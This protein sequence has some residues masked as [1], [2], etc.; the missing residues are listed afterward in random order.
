MIYVYAII[1]APDADL[2][3]APGLADRPV[4]FCR[5]GPIAAAFS[6]HAAGISPTSE[7][8][9]RHE[10]VVEQLMRERTLL[11]A[12]FDTTFADDAALASAVTTHRDAL[13][14]G[15]RR[16]R[17]C[18]ELGLRVLWRPPADPDAAAAPEP[19]I[20]AAAASASTTTFGRAY[21]LARLAE[22]R[23][24]AEG[25]RRAAALAAQVHDPLAGL[26]RESMRR[27][28]V[29]PEILLSAAYLVE[30]AAVAGFRDRI[31]QIAPCHPDLHLLCT[32]PWPPYHFAPA[33][34]PAATGGEYA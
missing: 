30:R 6:R 22:E 24:R 33:I 2:P 4:E 12:R 31:T 1:D 8:V 20:A 21:M 13:V 11:P 34:R 26:A 25:D 15:V 16:V 9:L 29:R 18:V 17:G 7:A 3:P 10:A 27:V 28:L 5:A 23:R 19:A 32:G 14:D